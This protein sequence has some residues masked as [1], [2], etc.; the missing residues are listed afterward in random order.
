M[1]KSFSFDDVLIVPRFSQIKSR[2]DVSLKQT[3]LGMEIDVP[4]ISS[5]MDSVTGPK[6]ASAMREQGALGALHRFCTIEENINMFLQ[7]PE[8]TIVSIGLGDKELQRAEASYQHGAWNFLID[9]AHGASMEVVNQYIDLRSIVKTNANIIVGNFATARNIKDFNKFLDKPADAYKV[10]IG[11]G[12]ACLTRVV[13]GCGLPTFASIQ[14]CATTGEVI[15]ADG[16]IRNSG[17]C[18]KALASGASLIMMGRMLAGCDE[19]PGENYFSQCWNTRDNC[20]IIR[21]VAHSECT[22][23]VKIGGNV[24]KR[25]RGS[26]SEESYEVQGKTASHRTPEGESFFVPHTGPVSEVLNNLSAGIK[27]GCSYV[28]AS[29]LDELRENVEF[30]GV[31]SNGTNESKAHGKV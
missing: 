21:P 24:L 1:N 15:I 7:S 16:G 2:A 30:V 6:M 31:T 28:G 29:N 8:E 19:S 13:T 17:D 5:N 14:D 4:F 12:S 22:R 23:D 27:S 3:L 20:L 11:G 10:G 25:Y 9:V 18:V 26:A